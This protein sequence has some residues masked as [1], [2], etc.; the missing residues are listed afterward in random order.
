[1]IIC[2]L[3]FVIFFFFFFFFLHGFKALQDYLKSGIH[4]CQ[5]FMHFEIFSIQFFNFFCIY[6]MPFFYVLQ[7]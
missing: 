4:L 6:H 2:W 7:I 5:P 3:N 1:M